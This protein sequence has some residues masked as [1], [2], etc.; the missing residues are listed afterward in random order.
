MTTLKVNVIRRPQIKVKVLPNFPSSV[1]ATSPIL[2]SS[3]GGNY[4]FSFDAT[5][6]EGTLGSLFQPLD[7]TLTALAGLNSTAGL[8]V[9][10]A[11]DTFTKRTL[12]GTA[13]EITMTNG[14]GVAGNPTASLPAALTF[15]GKTVTGGTFTSPAINGA[16]ILTSTY[17]KV[18]ITAPATAATLTLIDGTTL[19]GP[20]ASGTVM[21]L[22]NTET[23]TGIK[24]FGSAGAVGRL[25]IAGTTSGSTILDATAVASGT[26]TLP[27]ATDTLIGKATNDILTN[28]TYDTAGA[29]NS[30]SINSVAVTA[31]SGTG[32]IARATNP[33]FSGTVVINSSSSIIETVGNAVGNLNLAS[34]DLPSLIEWINDNTTS[35]V[36]RVSTYGSAG[37]GGQNNFHFIRMRGTAAAPTATQSGDFFLSYGL[38]GNDGQAGTAGNTLSTGAFQ[39]IATENWTSI[40]H[41]TKWRFETTP[42]GSVTRAAALDIWGS[43]GISVG[44]TSDPAGVGLINS[45]GLVGTTT[46]NNATT[47]CVGEVISS[48]VASGSAIGLTAS[49]AANITS[50]TLTAGDWDVSAFGGF[51]PAGTTSMTQYVASISTT[52]ATLDGTTPFAISKFSVAANV[53]AGLDSQLFAGPVRAS[54]TGST[55]YFLVVRAIFTV[56][57]LTSYGAIR[58]RRIR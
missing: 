39:G 17:N 22:G 7:T 6:F 32:A 21:T 45:N 1:T 5:A 43:G 42:N 46:N 9:E 2:L 28:K 37:L 57:T 40:A 36:F 3:V 11:A 48:S 15:T 24:T 47:G 23:V 14:D 55:T 18:T 34:G 27:A 29:G 31:N 56:S 54:L 53:P 58:A 25:K 33:T 16:T 30:F 10:T 8:L 49:T 52:S 26:L 20:A 13:A 19:T 41:G 38:R 50:I 51:I 44:G 12:I 4:A 35:Q